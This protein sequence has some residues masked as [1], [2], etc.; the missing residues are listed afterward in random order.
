VSLVDDRGRIGGKINLID[1]IVAALIVVLVPV[2]YGAYLLFRT[3]AAKLLTVQPNKLY[4]GPNL[5]VTVNGQNLRPFMRVAFG[6]VQGQTFLI[7]STKYA[8]VDL[9]DL[10]P[11]TYDIV[12]YDFM[13]EVDRLPKA[14]TVLPLAPT[15]TVE[16]QVA[17]AF[18]PVGDDVA[19]LLAVGLKFPPTG[20]PAAEILSLGP[21]RP[22]DM[23]MRAG[24]VTLNLPLPG[25]F[26]LPATLKI[27][28]FPQS[29][30]DGTLRCSVSGPQVAAT[31]APD[32]VLTLA[33]PAGWVNFQ[34]DEVHVAT[35]AATVDARVRF[36]GTQ[37]IAAR[38]KA[39]DTDTST[40]A[41]AVGH[42][43]VIVSLG[44]AR[45][46]SAAEAGPNPPIGGGARVIDAV[47]RVPIERSATGWRYKDRLLRAGEPFS[48]ETAGY[49]VGGEVSDVTLPPL[50]APGVQVK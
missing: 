25:Q 43:A 32:S 24:E 45:A 15:A 19:K 35:A 33:G 11:G 29:S 1:A 36:V 41:L 8:Q 37:E 46:V 20:D 3:P 49:T 12:L 18:R 30:A 34:I 39:G 9:P 38:M 16:M 40:K 10:G 5:R 27:K 50:T 14:L 23:R 17:G 48:F 47:V 4:Q 28:C 6:S 44:A 21:K 22:V 31:V 2:A 7:G 42:A 26:E 13:Q